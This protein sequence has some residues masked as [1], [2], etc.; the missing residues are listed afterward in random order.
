MKVLAQPF[1]LTIMSYCC[2]LLDGEV[3][4]SECI[5]MSR[6][7]KFHRSFDHYSLERKTRMDTHKD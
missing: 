7:W 2:Q 1:S 5:E 3:E 6:T 4:A